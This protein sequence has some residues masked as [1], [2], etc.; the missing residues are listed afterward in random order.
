MSDDDRF[1]DK[2]SKGAVVPRPRHWQLNEIL[3]GARE[4][5]IAHGGDQYRLRL[6]ANNKLILT[7]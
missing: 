5:I 4:A 7:K 1:Q 6:T 2:A 3:G